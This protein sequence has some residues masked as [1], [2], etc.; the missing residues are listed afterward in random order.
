MPDAAPETAPPRLGYCCVYVPP[1]GDK[2]AARRMNTCTTTIT[3]L[4]RLEQRAAFEKV[5][6]LVQHNMQALAAQI[7]HVGAQPPLER[8]LRLKSD[9]LPAYTH[10]VARWMY[11]DPAMQR[12]VRDGLAGV[13]ALARKL[14]VR[15]SL[16]P[17]QYCVLA[18]VND[19]TLAGAIDEFE[20][21]TDIM[22][23]AGYAGGWHRHGAHINIHIGSSVGGLERFR[24]GLA[25]LSAD[26]RGLITVENDEMMFGLDD[27][28]Q[29]ADVLPVVLDFH[30]HWVAS[31]GEYLQP[32]DPRIDRVRESWRGVRPVSH[33]SVSQESLLPDHPKDRLPDF[34]AL[35][36]AGL[37]PR[38]L[39]AHSEMMWNSAVNDWMAAQLVWTDLEVEAKGK[40][41]ASRQLAAQVTRN[42]R[43]Q[44][45]FQ[46]YS[47]S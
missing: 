43:L 15:L 32:G 30:H 14:G 4:S 33:I 37:K 11:A 12:L 22:R 13:G 18:T 9:I 6:G 19:T 3:A 20:Y 42:P 24:M 46:Q 1:D 40:N 21:H 10:P 7:A 41:L 34:T 39:R 2:Q 8:L 38:D 31:R 5:L 35:S 44:E 25:R 27:V 23:W 29:V 47:M 16:H 17:G 36:A 26:A 45:G 28:L